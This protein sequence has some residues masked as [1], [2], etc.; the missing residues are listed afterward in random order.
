MNY[1]YEDITSQ[2]N[3]AT[4]ER[5]VDGVYILASG[6]QYDVANS[7][8]TNKTIEGGTW[9]ETEETLT[10]IFTDELSTEDKTLLDTI[11]EN[12]EG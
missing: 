5:N 8:M 3:I 9:R 12:N 1:E 6:I 7:A 10:I 4:F 2:P 11:V